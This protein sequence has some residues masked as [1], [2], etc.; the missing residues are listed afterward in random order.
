MIDTRRVDLL[1]GPKT[2]GQT[3]EILRAALERES[4]W[5]SFV[6]SGAEAIDVS[7]SLVT[8]TRRAMGLVFMILETEG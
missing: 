7:I 5:D 6:A 2:D 1:W 4:L 8:Q 3:L